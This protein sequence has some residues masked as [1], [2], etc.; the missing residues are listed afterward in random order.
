MIALPNLGVRPS[1]N[2]RFSNLSWGNMRVEYK[3]ASN[4][5]LLLPPNYFNGGVYT[6]SQV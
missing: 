4:L 5:P 2:L 1:L 6:P 3:S